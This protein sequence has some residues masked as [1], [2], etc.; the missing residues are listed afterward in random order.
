M[1]MINLD[2]Q[3]E[4]ALNQ[5]AAEEGKTPDAWIMETLRVLVNRAEVVRRQLTQGN[6]KEDDFFTLA[7][8]WSGRD[9]D[10]QTL[11]KEAWPKS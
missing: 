10:A 3:T 11:R 5:L 7:G 6:T 1:Y 2:E 8:L 4:S 9:I